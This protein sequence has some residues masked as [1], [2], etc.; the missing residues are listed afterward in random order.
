[1]EKSM[2]SKR[3]WR[4]RFVGLT[5]GVLLALLIWPSTSWL[6]RSHL[7]LAVPTAG[8]VSPWVT[9]THVN[10]YN[11][12][13][14]RYR[15][16]AERN[17]D[18]FTLQYGAA[19]GVDPHVEKF[20]GVVRVE[21]LR[22]LSRR[23][24]ERPALLAAILRHETMYDVR[25][26]RDEV[27]WLDGETK[28]NHTPSHSSRNL[29]DVLAAYDRD[30]A[31]GERL[32][33]DNGY[34]PLMRSIGLF[35]AHRDQE[36]LAAVER[37]ASKP[38]WIEYYG[39]EVEAEERLQDAT[40]GRTGVLPRLAIAWSIL[41]PHYAQLRSTSRLAT[42]L[43][44]RRE[45]A[46]DIEGGAAIRRSVIRCGSLMRKGSSSLIGSLV[47]M[48]VTQLA[49]TRPGGSPVIREEPGGYAARGRGNFIGQFSGHIAKRD[50]GR[51]HDQFIAYFSKHGQEE[52][53]AEVEREV[54]AGL[55]A[56]EVIKT[57]DRSTLDTG[58]QR[59]A[60]YWI[61]AQVL[62]SDALL[63][64]LLGGLATL[65]SRHRS[66]RTGA[67]WARGAHWSWA[68]GVLF[69]GLFLFSLFAWQ[70]GESV[71]PQI[72]T[73]W[74]FIVTSGAPGGTNFDT[75]RL[76]VAIAM[77]VPGLLLLGLGTLSLAWRVPLSVGVIRGLKGIALPL[78][79]GFALAYAVL[80]PFIIGREAALETALTRTV[81]HE[82]RYL[83]EL[84]GKPW[85]D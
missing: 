49:L 15:E 62:V 53:V 37:A 5:V 1:M 61:A 68:P 33:P 75:Q 58:P 31:E 7:R 71:H 4:T 72:E 35:V 18:D 74:G 85:P 38:K 40:Y 9:A 32:D 26:A 42:A 39:E 21:R 36:G 28:P 64:L 82:G 34:F 27:Y 17:P 60:L 80:V 54:A 84:S 19:V 24:P 77:A 46:G 66:I 43:A 73:M 29:E 25:L 44:A 63:M 51:W 78:A 20:A 79:C 47:G 23:F 65:L 10:A 14:D 8:R 48:A 22:N 11:H 30:A 83:A 52:L 70:V 57:L 67:G 13:M 41:F 3:S 55:Q 56:R 45:M 12:R 2:S 6:V 76:V 16:T 50:R 81:Q 69:G 59:L